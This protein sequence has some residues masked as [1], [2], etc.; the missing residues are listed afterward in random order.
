VRARRAAWLVLAVST[1]IYLAVVLVWQPAGFSD[2][3]VYRAEA[4]ALYDGRDLYG[5]LPGVHGLATYPPFAA[6]AFAPLLLVPDGVAGLISLPVNLALL[7][8]AAYLS[9]R[10]VSRPVDLRVAVPLLAAAAPWCEPVMSSNDFGQINLA[11]LCLVLWDLGLPEGS[12]WRGVGIGVATALKVT[13]AIFIVYLV[14]T[15]RFRAAAGAVGTLIATLA[16]SAVLAPSSTWGYWTHHVLEPSRVGRLENSVNQ[17]VRGWIVR[18]TH[19]LEPSAV[20]TAATVLV[21]AVG[22]ASAVYVYR[23]VGDEWGVLVVALT[24]LL[25]SPISW[26]HHWVWCVPLLALAWSESR[27]L[28]VATLLVFWTHVVRLVPHG[29]HVE[30]GLDPGQVAMSGWY[31]VYA[32]AFVTAAVVVAMKR[33]DARPPLPDRAPVPAYSAGA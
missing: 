15:G 3:S 30:L 29:D 7:L 8:A 16:V 9:L 11:I 12:R 33:E 21:A 23:H 19:S 17:S 6:A 20:T 31:V 13:P 18:A 5:P 10:R 27:A 28:F 25:V 2:V 4:R 1:T 14:V 26:S 22:L 24:G 32:A